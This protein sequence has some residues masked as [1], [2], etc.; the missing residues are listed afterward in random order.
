MQ[1]K[2]TRHLT[3]MIPEPKRG[4]KAHKPMASHGLFWYKESSFAK[5]DNVMRLRITMALLCWLWVLVSL[6]WAP[7]AA[8]QGF[9]YTGPAAPMAPEFDRRG[10]L[11]QPGAELSVSPSP[12]SRTSGSREASEGPVDYRTVR[13]YVPQGSSPKRVTA[14]VAPRT[15]EY[16]PSPGAPAP[17]AAP[18]LPSPSMGQPQA[19][20]VWRERPD[21]SAYPLMISQ[22]RSQGEMQTLA[23]EYLTCLM[24]N[25]WDMEQAKKHVIATIET[26]Y[27]PGR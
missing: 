4:V 9:P 26:T 13:P 21:C 19:Q 2:S 27:L 10:N 14:P 12:P 7:K 18:P 25:G 20:P 24:K 15:P 5:R 6:L 3:I 11:L 23:R 16:Q 1:R 17:V 22:A 8:A